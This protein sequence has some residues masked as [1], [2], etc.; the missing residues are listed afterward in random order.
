MSNVILLS[1]V[2]LAILNFVLKQ[3]NK[4]NIMDFKKEKNYESIQGFPHNLL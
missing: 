2:S 4:E 3:G 1:L